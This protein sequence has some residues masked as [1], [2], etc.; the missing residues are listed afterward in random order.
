VQEAHIT[1]IQILCGMVEE[2]LF[3][4]VPKVHD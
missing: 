4:D 3:A 2:T 1:V